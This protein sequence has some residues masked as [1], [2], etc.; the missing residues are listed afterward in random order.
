LVAPQVA[1]IEHVAS[2]LGTVA[3]ADGAMHRTQTRI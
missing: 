2:D 3:V 1:A